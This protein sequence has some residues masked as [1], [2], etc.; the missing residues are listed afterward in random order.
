MTTPTLAEQ[1]AVITDIAAEDLSFIWRGL[2]PQEATEALFDMLP[3]VIDTWAAAAGA[4]SADWYDQ[5]RED[6]DIAG[7][8]TAIIPDLG[9]AGADELAGWASQAIDLDEPDWDLARSRVDGGMQRR[10]TNTS[11][12]T[13]IK[14]S[15]EDPHAR[16]WQRV[17]RAG[18]CAFC[19]M[20]AGRGTIYRAKNVRFGAHD[21]CHCSAVPAWGGRAV[22]VK[23]YKPSGRRI[24]AADRARVREWISANQ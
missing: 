16:G 5:R 11:R 22:P 9:D 19:V 23:P 3:S 1:V 18:G 13:I 6:A 4:L 2:S 12:E 20:L 8:F 21:H 17:A 24:T 7:R 15:L 14:S 10:I